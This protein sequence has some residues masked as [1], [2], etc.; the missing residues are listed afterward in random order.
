M[1]PWSF[2]SLILQSTKISIMRKTGNKVNGK[3]RAL[4]VCRWSVSRWC[5]LRAIVVRDILLIRAPMLAER[6]SCNVSNSASWIIPKS[7][8]VFG[9][10]SVSHDVVKSWSETRI[11][12]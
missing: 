9:M 4:I 6:E 3:V 1:G 10:S 2:T 7:I 12:L 11:S 8:E 5:N